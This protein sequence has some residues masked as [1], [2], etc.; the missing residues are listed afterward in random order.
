MFYDVIFDIL[1]EYNEAT[2]RNEVYLFRW[3]SEFFEGL[4]LKHK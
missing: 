2:F 3:I 4:N 1:A